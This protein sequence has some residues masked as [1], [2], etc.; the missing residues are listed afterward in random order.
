MVFIFNKLSINLTWTYVSC[1]LHITVRGHDFRVK[2]FFPTCTVTLSIKCNL[3]FE[4]RHSVNEK[5][6]TLPAQSLCQWNVIFSTSIV[7]LSIKCNLPYQH[8]HSANQLFVGSVILGSTDVRVCKVPYGDSNSEGI[9]CTEHWI[10]KIQFQNTCL[11]KSS[12]H[13]KGS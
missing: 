12:C 3:P 2:H 1:F 9:N 6:L 4:H 11:K 7:T 5:Y 8:S 13:F 10:C